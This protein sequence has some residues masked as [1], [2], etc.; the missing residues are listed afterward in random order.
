MGLDYL[1]LQLFFFGW[2]FELS[3]EDYEPFAML[4]VEM[5]IHWV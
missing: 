2:L 3:S 5:S 1:F 4:G